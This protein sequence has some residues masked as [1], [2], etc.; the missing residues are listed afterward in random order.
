M[1]RPAIVPAMT[2]NNFTFGPPIPCTP[3]LEYA[4]GKDVAFAYPL[5]E[6]DCSTPPL[7]VNVLPLWAGYGTAVEVRARV[8]DVKDWVCSTVFSESSS[9]TESV[10]LGAILV[11]ESPSAELL[12]SPVKIPVPELLSFDAPFEPE[13]AAASAAD[14]VLASG[15]VVAD[16]DC[17]VEVT[18]PGVVLVS[19]EGDNARELLSVNILEGDTSE[20]DAG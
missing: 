14:V 19:G 1:V 17:S 13:A 11:T 4:I 10:A 7:A 18:D 15:N 20:G 5:A 3:S 16:G 8:V 12:E 6:S 2:A 9:A